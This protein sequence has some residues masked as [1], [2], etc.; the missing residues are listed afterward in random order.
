MVC[1]SG[2]WRSPPLPLISSTICSEMRFAVPPA[3]GASI[4]AVAFMTAELLCRSCVRRWCWCSYHLNGIVKNYE[5]LKTEELPSM[6]DF[7]PD[8]SPPRMLVMSRSG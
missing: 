5:L 3:D 2:R 8:V 7:D 1:I 4:A 6:F